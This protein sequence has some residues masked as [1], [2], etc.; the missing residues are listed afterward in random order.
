MLISLSGFT[1]FQLHL[2]LPAWCHAYDTVSWEK[3]ETL[4]SLYLQINLFFL[5]LLPTSWYHFFDAL[6]LQNQW[7]FT[8]VR[9][10]LGWALMMA[11]KGGRGSHRVSPLV[12][13]WDV[14]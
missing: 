8:N 12:A 7:E 13:V 14:C 3:L 6:C 5:Q 1:N 9:F 4:L 2:L 11:G 10:T